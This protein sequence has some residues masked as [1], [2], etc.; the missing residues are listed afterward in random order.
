MAC[1]DTTRVPSDIT[2]A[3]TGFSRG[4]GTA[5]VFA[6]ILNERGLTNTDGSVVLAPG[7]VPVVSTILFDPVLTGIEGN[8]SLPPNVLGN[9]LVLQALDEFRYLF[10]AA[11]FSNDPRVNVLQY[12]GNHGNIGGFYD[13]GIGALILE[14]STNFIRNSGIAIFDVPLNRQFDGSADVNVYTEATRSTDGYRIYDEYGTRGNRLTQRIP[15]PQLPSD[16]NPDVDRIVRINNSTFDPND[17]TVVLT[18]FFKD[19][20]AERQLLDGEGNSV[21]NASRGETL[22]RDS[23][24]GAY[25]IDNA[26]TLESRSFNPRT[27]ELSVSA[28]HRATVVMDVDG[29]VLRLIEPPETVIDTS[30]TGGEDFR[31]AANGISYRRTFTGD[32]EFRDDLSGS[33]AFTKISGSGSLQVGS[34]YQTVFSDDGSISKV[35]YSDSGAVIGK[36]ETT[37]FAD[38]RYRSD[39]KFVDGK[40][41]ISEFSAQGDLYKTT[42][43]RP[44]ALNTTQ[45]ESYAYNTDG[46]PILQSTR[47]VQVFFDD[48]GKSIIETVTTF[49]Q[50]QP[51]TVRIVYN[52]DGSVFNTT[53]IAPSG[54]AARL[55]D[56]QTTTVLNDIAS[57]VSAIQSGRP[58]PILN[59][60]LSLLNNLSTSPNPVLAN[61]TGIVSGLSSLYNLSNAFKN[62]NALSKTNAALSSLN[63]VNST[64][65]TLLNNGT[66]TVLNSS[67]NTVL[68]GSGGV[69]GVLPVLGLIISIKNGDPIGIVSGLIGIFNPVLLTTPPV[70]WLLAGASI[71]RALFSDNT[72]PE[73]WGTAKFIFDTNG[74]LKVD[75]VGVSFGKDRVQ[76]QLR[77]EERRVGKEC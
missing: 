33:G 59:S 13:N 1:C 6:Q 27:G 61:T 39:L 50:G 17:P 60:G 47:D 18:V 51:S 23:V 32:I 22:T 25:R 29:N 21:L 20:T 54:S 9:V 28:P 40:V 37:F 70:G 46:R 15:A 14:A 12:F 49:G 75:V 76:R 35:I 5:I 44:S 57:L 42:I 24:S 67:L 31:L 10:R 73:A 53:N 71:L 7:Q 69:P 3:M 56:A 2:T 8:L 63:Y 52:N 4:A 65:P 30:T 26:I 19:G 58:L 74:Q 62:G 36:I 72:P 11:D 66:S 45:V 55:S 34:T 64:L 43:L 16:S 77:S 38:G 48:N 41:E 68:N